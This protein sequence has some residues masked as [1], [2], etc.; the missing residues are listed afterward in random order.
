[1]EKLP[2]SQ[3]LRNIMEESRQREVLIR[4]RMEWVETR[5]RQ[6]W[7]RQAELD[8]VL[9]GMPPLPDAPPQ[10]RSPVPP[11]QVPEPVTP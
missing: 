1:M 11:P 10:V 3:A 8:A 2:L 7:Q 9:S 4:E 5:R 6:L